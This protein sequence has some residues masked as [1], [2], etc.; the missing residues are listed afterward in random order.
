M[1]NIRH[2]VKDYHKSRIMPNNSR[3]YL[4]NFQED[5]EDK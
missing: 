1:W 2:K 5:E 4:V 3:K